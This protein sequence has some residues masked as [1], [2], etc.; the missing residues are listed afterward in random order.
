MGEYEMGA[1]VIGGEI[2]VCGEDADDAVGI[3]QMRV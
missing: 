1:K 2:V 3:A